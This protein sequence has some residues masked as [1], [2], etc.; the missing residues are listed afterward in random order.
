MNDDVEMGNGAA[1]AAATPAKT[2]APV[3]PIPQRY[4]AAVEHPA[5]L[6][7]LQRGIDSFAGRADYADIVQP[8][9]PQSSTAVFLRPEDPA[10]SGLSSHCAS[11]H[12]LV[13]AVHV[14]KRTGMRRKRGTNDAWEHAPGASNGDAFSG[15]RPPGDRMAERDARRLRK[16]LQE[17]VGRYRT[18]VIGISKH[19]HRYRGVMDFQQS[20]HDSDFMTKFTETVLPGECK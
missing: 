18:E 15:D 11:S 3:L 14:P 4:L 7:S 10:S 2:T 19:S 5:F 13:V 1:S 20:T 8:S 17:T 9:G 12:N 6:T 16:R